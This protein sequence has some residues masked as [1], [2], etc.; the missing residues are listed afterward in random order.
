MISAKKKKATVATPSAIFPKI[1]S[2][3][4][5]AR[6]FIQ[7]LN[8]E[9]AA[10]GYAV[11]DDLDVNVNIENFNEGNRA[12]RYL[13]GFGAGKATSKIVTTLVDK[14]SGKIVGHIQ[15][16]GMLAMGAFGGNSGDILKR[17]AKDIAKKIAESG[18]LKKEK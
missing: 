13:V 3:L 4:T 9:L 6:F 17:S 10:L 7:N 12:L 18:I 14:E 11:G 5:P 16:D 8:H 2:H 15:T 1:I